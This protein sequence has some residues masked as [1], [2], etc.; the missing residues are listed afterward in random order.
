MGSWICLRLGKGEQHRELAGCFHRVRQ[1]RRHWVS[2]A[3]ESTFSLFESISGF[4]F[5]H[6]YHNRP[7]PALP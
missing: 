6:R 3:S 4:S 1:I 2:A 7:P 5:M